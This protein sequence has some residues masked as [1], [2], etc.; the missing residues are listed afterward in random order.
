V[1]SWRGQ[2]AGVVKKSKKPAKALDLDQKWK[3]VYWK[4]AAYS[5]SSTC[6]GQDRAEKAYL[7]TAACS[8]NS[9]QTAI[10]YNATSL[11]DSTFSRGSL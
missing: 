5:F 2:S 8:L 10:T 7:Y 11:A 3:D 6:C 4:G 1:K 9:S